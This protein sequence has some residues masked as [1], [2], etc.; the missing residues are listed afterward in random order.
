M[1]DFHSTYSQLPPLTLARDM[2]EARN[3]KK[4]LAGPIRDVFLKHGMENEYGVSLLHRHFDMEPKERLVEYH[5]VSTPWVLD[6]NESVVPVL[7]GYVV[8]QNFKVDNGK[9]SPFEFAMQYDQP[10]GTPVPTEFV[11]DLAQVLDAGDLSGVLG[12]RKRSP[13]SDLTLEVT[14]G[15]ANIMVSGK[16]SNM[17][18]VEAFWTFSEGV[19]AEAVCGQVCSVF[20]GVH[21]PEHWGTL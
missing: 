19:D 8:P 2:F 12:L 7:G 3:T 17:P 16:G 14:Q 4:H 11:Q 15:R 18:V 6:S 21:F 1:E 13:E 10:A 5:D 9:L 20:C